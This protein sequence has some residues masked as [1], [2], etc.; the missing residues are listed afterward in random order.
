MTFVIFCHSQN[1]IHSTERQHDAWLAR[2]TTKR[3]MSAMWVTDKQENV[4]I[5]TAYTYA[6]TH[7]CNWLSE[8]ATVCRFGYDSLSV[9]DIKSAFCL[10][11]ACACAFVCTQLTVPSKSSFTN[12]CLHG[13][14]DCCRQ[15][16]P[17]GFFPFSNSNSTTKKKSK[18]K[19]CPLQLAGWFA[20]L[21][22]FVFTYFRC[23]KKNVGSIY[24]FAWLKIIMKSAEFLRQTVQTC[25]RFI[26]MVLSCNQSILKFIVS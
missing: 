2:W 21:D 15:H 5:C 26:Q 11:C 8:N 10:A 7:T 16:F 19:M 24:H 20:L 14:Y 17:F 23:K 18:W 1:R 6:N 25:F 9:H 13:T 3:E 22:L 4:Y 12:H